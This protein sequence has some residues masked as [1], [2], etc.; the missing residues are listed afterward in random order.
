[1][2]QLCSRGALLLPGLVH[3]GQVGAALD[4]LR[5]HDGT[6]R[7]DQLLEINVLYWLKWM[8]AMCLVQVGGLSCIACIFVPESAD[9]W[10][11][12][13]LAMVGKFQIALSFAVIYG[14]F[15]QQPRPPYC[16]VQCM[17]GS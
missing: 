10:W 3:H 9:P 11:I 14:G 15:S 4:P 2:L 7:S 8:K 6:L 5:N 1:M 12:V 13:S 17:P 16:D